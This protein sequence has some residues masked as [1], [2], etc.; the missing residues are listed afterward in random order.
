VNKADITPA[1][2]A[3]LVAEQFPQWADLRV[4]RVEI[5]GW[6]N[7]TFRLGDELSVRL[8]SADGYV[9]Q[10]DKEHRWLS[11][12]ARH[13]PL[14]IPEP[15]AMGHPGGGFARPWSIYRWI[16][17]DPASLAPIA[18]L[19]GFATDLARFLAA[20]YTVDANDGPPPG[21]HNFFRGASLKTF[22]AEM[23]TKRLDADAGR[24]IE[25]LSDEIDA[26]AA[27]E[28]WEAALASVWDRPPVWVHGDVS[29]SNLLVIDGRLRAVIDFG[30]A[31]VGDPAC[32]LVMAWNFFAGES[33]DEFR[34]GL[35]FDDVTWARARGWALWKA[36]IT[37]VREREGGENALTAA[38]RFGWR[39]TPREVVDLVLA[40]HHR[41]I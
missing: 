18:D 35:P 3:G 36:L 8:P 20:L 9:A 28:V 23:K 26:E 4:E 12:L 7:A 38:R 30:C 11:I 37:I 29:P 39:H 6:D 41:S 40:D 14:P 1:V 25:L 33:R 19:T 22:A 32:D 17:G 15:V 5:D 16:E 13:L 31:G 10:V 34:R 27:T 24:S 21:W 2:V